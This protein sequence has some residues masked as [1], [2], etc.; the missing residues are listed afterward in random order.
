MNATRLHV[1]LPRH[2][3]HTLFSERFCR[4][5]PLQITVPT[6]AGPKT[7]DLSERLEQWDI[8]AQGH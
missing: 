6:P 4:R 8:P 3:L 1:Y 5:F 2:Q 7:F